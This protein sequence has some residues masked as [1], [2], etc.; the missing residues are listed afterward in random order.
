[1]N[2]ENCNDAMTWTSGLASCA[3]Q[4]I[5]PPIYTILYALSPLLLLF[6]CVLRL[7]LLPPY[8][9]DT[10]FAHL[11]KVPVLDQNWWSV[12]RLRS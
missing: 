9:A 1:M 5:M 8:F 2:H 4:C 10:L 11:L 6:V 12:Y 3:K 7:D